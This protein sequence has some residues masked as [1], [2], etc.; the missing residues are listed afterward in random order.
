MRI[1]VILRDIYFIVA[2][3]VFHQK[4]ETTCDCSAKTTTSRAGDGGH[5]LHPGTSFP[6]C[7]LSMNGKNNKTDV[8][9]EMRMLKTLQGICI[10]CMLLKIP[11]STKKHN[12]HF[13][14]HFQKVFF[15]T[16]INSTV[17]S[18]YCSEKRNGRNGKTKSNA[19]SSTC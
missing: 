13:R 6:G 16:V 3:M 18:R 15:T 9:S 14:W 1:G 2:L 17:S 8:S 4:V 19:K 11:D 5:V 7:D 10:V 12:F